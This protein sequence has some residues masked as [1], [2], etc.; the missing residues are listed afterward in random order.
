MIPEGQIRQIVEKV[1]WDYYAGKQ[2]LPRKSR[3]ALSL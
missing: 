1:V 2:S 3:H